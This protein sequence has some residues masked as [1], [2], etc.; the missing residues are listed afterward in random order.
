[1]TDL[2]LSEYPEAKEVLVT[3]T[4]NEWSKLIP[5]KKDTR[6]PGFWS[7]RVHFPLTTACYKFL[8]KVRTPDQCP[9]MLNSR[10]TTYSSWLT[11]IGRPTLTSPRKSTDTT[12]SII[13][14]TSKFGIPNCQRYR[15]ALFL[16]R[17]RLLSKCQGPRKRPSRRRSRARYSPMQKVNCSPCMSS[18]RKDKIWRMECAVMDPIDSKSTHIS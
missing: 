17:R 10:T 4:F 3:G 5:L 13:S 16:P 11:A 8:Y 1:M 7:M 2:R 18:Y 12:T 6:R 14:G 9:N 15:G